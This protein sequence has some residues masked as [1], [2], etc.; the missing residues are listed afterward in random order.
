M[1]VRIELDPYRCQAY[2]VCV[3]IAPTYFDLPAG[4]QVV[5]LLRRDADPADVENL[6]EAVRHCPVKAL[7]LVEAGN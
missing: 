4:A 3:A 5:T 2:G 7:A 6:R 1:D